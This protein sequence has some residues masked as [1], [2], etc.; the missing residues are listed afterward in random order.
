[1]DSFIRC[2]IKAFE[3]F[4]AA[5]TAKIDN[6]KAGVITPNFYEPTIQIQY[7]EFLKHYNAPITARVRRGQ[8][9]GKVEAGV[10]YIKSNFLKRIESIQIIS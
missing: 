10:K 9:K 1:M 3:Y 7:A 8:D 5:H 6:L 2:H 4:G